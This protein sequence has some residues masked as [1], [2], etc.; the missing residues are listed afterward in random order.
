MSAV[1]LAA[2]FDVIENIALL[3]LIYGS[4][5]PFWSSITYYFAILKFAILVVAIVYVLGGIGLLLYKKS[6]K[7]L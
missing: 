1:F 6:V 7:I 3:Q 2:F 5:E 4:L